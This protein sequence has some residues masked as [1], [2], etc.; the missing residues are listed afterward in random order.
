MISC[1]NILVTKTCH[2]KLV[3]AQNLWY[4]ECVFLV[5]IDTSNPYGLMSGLIKYSMETWISRSWFYEGT[6]YFG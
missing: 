4:S 3:L 6:C 2:T 5:L 1:L